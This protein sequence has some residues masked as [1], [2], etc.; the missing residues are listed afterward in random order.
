VLSGD[1]FFLNSS[2]DKMQDRWTIFQFRWCAACP[3]QVPRAAIRPSTRAISSRG[4]EG[5]GDVIVGAHFQADY[6]VGFV[7]ARSQHQNRQAV[8]RFILANFAGKY[9]S[10]KVSEALSPAKADR[11][12]IFF[13]VLRPVTPS[14]APLTWNPS[15]ARFVAN[16]F[17]DVAIIFNNQDTFSF[18]WSVPVA[19][20]AG[21]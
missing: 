3:R 9:P 18:G 4:T 15:L 5:L 2:R 19:S 7:T 1:R 10:R 14:F 13:K 16:Q 21:V 11:A 6:A 12:E 17:N 20:W 8:Q